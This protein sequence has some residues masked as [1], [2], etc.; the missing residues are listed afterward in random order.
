MLYS[1]TRYIAYIW[2]TSTTY[3]EGY[4]NH[5]KSFNHE[6]YE[7]ETELSKYV[8]KLKRK[9]SK[10]SITWKIISHATTKR[11]PTNQCNLCLEEKYQILKHSEKNPCLLLNKR[12]EIRACKLTSIFNNHKLTSIYRIISNSHRNHY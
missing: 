2:L 4:N 5:N 7:N 8:C 11:R 10:F 1:S 12:L 3:K 9:N 6:K